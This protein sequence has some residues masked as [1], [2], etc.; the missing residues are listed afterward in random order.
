MTNTVDLCERLL[1]SFVI[2]TFNSAR[3]ELNLI[4]RIVK[5]TI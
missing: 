1:K 3:A 2:G 5:P 4:P